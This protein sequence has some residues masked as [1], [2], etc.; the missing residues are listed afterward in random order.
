MQTSVPGEG[1]KKDGSGMHLSV[2]RG[3]NACVMGSFPL[4]RNLNSLDEECL[5]EAGEI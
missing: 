1:S 3:Y 2:G 5:E 4:Q